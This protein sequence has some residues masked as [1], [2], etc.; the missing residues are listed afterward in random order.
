MSRV[1]TVYNAGSIDVPRRHRIPVYLVIT[2]T[3]SPNVGLPTTHMAERLNFNVK[4][5]TKNHLY[6]CLL[7]GLLHR[8]LENIE[9]RKNK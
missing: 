5:P 3:Q 7:Y 1:V 8:K 9:A 2:M 6:T 4:F